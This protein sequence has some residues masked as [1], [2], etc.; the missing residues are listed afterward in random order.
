MDTVRSWAS[1]MDLRRAAIVA[2][3]NAAWVGVVLVLL[4]AIAAAPSLYFPGNLENVVRQSAI[5]GVVS[6][7]QTFVLLGRGFDLSVGAV[8]G[9]TA[10][11]ITQASG[12]H[13]RTAW[14]A[15]LLALAMGMLVG[16]VNGW[17]VVRRSVPPFIA[18][19]G[20]LIFISGV[21]LAYTKG[22]F[23]GTVPGNVRLLAIGQLGPLPVPLLIWVAVAAV[24]AFA[25]YRT[26]AGRWLYAAG[27]NPV[28]ARLSG[29]PVGAVIAATFVVSGALAV[30]AGTLLTG[31]T[32]YVDQYLG[33]NA[34]LDS[35]T[36]A[37]IGGTS[38]A[39]GQGGVGGTI[40]GVVLL[41]LLV[42]LV[43]LLNFSV[44][45]QLVVK[46]LVLVLAVA[47]QGL[48]QRL[49]MG[50]VRSSVR[51]GTVSFG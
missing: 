32:G 24:A 48:R 12:F 35:I 17:L 30:V 10:T 19:L 51:R 26:F 29:V 2:S 18:T 14:L 4:V 5:L 6:V 20:M 15:F 39:G 44:Q 13:G 40:A 49:E 50:F 37:I 47:L 31:Y 38:F 45:L 11:V 36:A 33:T 27:A 1:G 46:G 41:T 3:R 23:S 8:M 9:L 7:G 42:N 28:T 25:L 21:R 43:V 16:L 34:E 22:A